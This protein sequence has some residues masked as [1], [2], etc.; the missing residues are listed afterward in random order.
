MASEAPHS[1]NKRRRCARHGI[2]AG[3]DGQCALCRSEA[4]TPA[5]PTLG[6]LFGGVLA[7]LLLV[8]V[9]VWAYR[10]ATSSPD[11]AIA[12][13]PAS[14]ASPSSASAAGPTASATAEAP[15]ALAATAEQAA[16]VPSTEPTS[17]P[18][19]AELPAPAPSV[20]GPS[21]APKRPPLTTA[22]FQTALSATPVVIYT[23]SWCTVCRKAKGFLN[24]N[25][26]HYREIDVDET[27]GGWDTVQ[28]LSGSRGV[29]VIIVDGDMSS[30]LNPQAV[31]HS[32]ARSMER[33]LG[34]TGISFSRG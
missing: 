20:S 6:R 18:E 32:V 28:R 27:P 24:A 25:G 22:E 12:P 34:V 5:G 30:G 7:A 23:A 17:P 29:P 10:R 3:P 21:A 16:S 8:S 19:L 2:A 1:S 31:M 26:L 13:L 14:S 15:P 33:R 4:V 11:V 9:G